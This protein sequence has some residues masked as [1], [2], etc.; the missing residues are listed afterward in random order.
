MTN[1]PAQVL[2]GQHTVVAAAIRQGFDQPGR[3]HAGEIWQKLSE[4]LRLRWPK[5]TD[6]MNVNEHELP[7]CMSL[8]RQPRTKLRSTNPTA[9]LNKEGKRLADIVGIFPNAPSTTQPIGALLFERNDKWKSARCCMTVEAFA[10]ID[11]ENTESPLN[12]A[13]DAAGSCI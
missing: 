6:L 7:A 13:R 9:R 1:A 8:P 12:I 10:P 3:A 2:H 4:S 11:A 5:L